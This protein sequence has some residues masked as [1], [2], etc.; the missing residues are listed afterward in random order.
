VY[1]CYVLSLLVRLNRVAPGVTSDKLWLDG[2]VFVNLCRI[3]ASEEL[4]NKLGLETLLNL[5]LCSRGHPDCSFSDILVG[6]ELLNHL[7]FEVSMCTKE[8]VLIFNG[9]NILSPSFLINKPLTLKVK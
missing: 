9:I 1:G 5:F 6:L 8:N 4:L 2:L 3:L 7:F